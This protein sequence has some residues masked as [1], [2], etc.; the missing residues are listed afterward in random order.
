[1]VV[2]AVAV[3]VAVVQ[4]AVVQVEVAVVVTHAQM[5]SLRVEKVVHQRQPREE[6]VVADAAQERARR[7]LLVRH[8]QRRR[9]EGGNGTKTSTRQQ[10]CVANSK[11]STMKSPPGN[12]TRNTR[13]AMCG[14]S[15]TEAGL[16]LLVRRSP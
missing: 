1:M 7:Q 15:T 11:A 10:A 16:L 8:L 9:G 13:A 12:D 14:W 3:A 2:V 5:H 4:V 6:N